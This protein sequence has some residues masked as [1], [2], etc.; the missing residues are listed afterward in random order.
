MTDEQAVGDGPL[1]DRF[2]LEI[3]DG[4][5]ALRFPTRREAL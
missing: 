5:T 1:F 2:S 3:K 4:Q